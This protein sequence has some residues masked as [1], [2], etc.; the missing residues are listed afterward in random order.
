MA[1]CQTQNIVPSSAL[2]RELKKKE[3]ERLEPL[4]EDAEDAA[5]GEGGSAPGEQGDAAAQTAA[6]SPEVPLRDMIP[7]NFTVM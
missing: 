6:A 3:K 7:W 4:M 5:G 1:M 2:Q